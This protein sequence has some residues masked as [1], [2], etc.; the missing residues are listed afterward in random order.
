MT[1]LLVLLEDAGAVRMGRKVERVAQAGSVQSLVKRA[2]GL[3]ETRRMVDHTRIEMM[4]RYAELTDCRRRFLLTYF[5]AAAAPK[6]CGNCDNCHAGRSLA[7]ARPSA[8][9]LGSRV[10]HSTFGRGTV[11]N[12]THER[13]TVL[14]DEA[15]YR[16]LVGA[17][18]LENRL[19][20]VHSADEPTERTSRRR[21][22]TRR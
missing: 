1:A 13:V 17:H 22:R 9:P 21:P 2:I 11:I 12:G 18:L 7:R 5:G 8:L 14:F 4:R 6:A 10:D 16:E 3:A 20:T 19:L 15:G